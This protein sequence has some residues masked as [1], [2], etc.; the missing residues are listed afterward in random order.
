MKIPFAAAAALFPT[1]LF[2]VDVHLNDLSAVEKYKDISVAIADGYISPD[3][4]HCVS[5]APKACP[6]IW[7]L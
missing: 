1:A 4:N 5:A 2:A 6:P 7:A 3:D